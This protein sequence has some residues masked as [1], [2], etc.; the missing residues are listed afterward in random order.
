MHLAGRHVEIET[1]QGAGRTEALH[2]PGRLDGSCHGVDRVPRSVAVALAKAPRTASTSMLSVMAR[3]FASVG[4]TMRHRVAD[5]CD[6][7][8]VHLAAVSRVLVANSPMSRR[9]TR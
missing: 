7:S 9:V 6:R 1:V 3:P 4:S 8:V 5:R 2:Q